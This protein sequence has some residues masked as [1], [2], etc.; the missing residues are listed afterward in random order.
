MCLSSGTVSSAKTNQTHPKDLASVTLPPNGDTHDTSLRLDH[1]AKN[2]GIPRG[3]LSF[4]P[5]AGIVICSVGS[6]SSSTVARL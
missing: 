5:V 1:E 2:R 4:I 3:N 6:L